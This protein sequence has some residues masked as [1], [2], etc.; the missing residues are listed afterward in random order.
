[1]VNNGFLNENDMLQNLQND[2]GNMC[3]VRGMPYQQN[4]LENN[5]N[6]LELMST[7]LQPITSHSLPS[8]HFNDENASLSIEQQCQI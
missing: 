6:Y 8:E 3:R 7:C 4:I 5:L 1:M 2:K